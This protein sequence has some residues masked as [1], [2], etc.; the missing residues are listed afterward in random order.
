MTEVHG[1]C[2]FS[3]TIPLQVEGFLAMKYMSSAFDSLP[4]VISIAK[5]LKIIP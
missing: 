5:L 4:L 2:G 3:L 1:V